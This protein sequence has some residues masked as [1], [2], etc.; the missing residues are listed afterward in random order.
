M[1]P[2]VDAA[3]SH[4]DLGFII[5]RAVPDRIA[6]MIRSYQA[7]FA[8]LPG[9]KS[10]WAQALR[11]A[12]QYLPFVE[13]ALPQYLDELRGLA[14]GSGAT[15]DELLLCNCFE[16]LT[17][18]MLF[19]KCTT[20]AFAPEHTVDGH[21]LLGHTEDW[22][23]I[24]RDWQYVVRARPDDEPAFISPV[25]GGLLPNVGF[26]AGGLAQCINTVYPD[27][28]RVGI[29][30][31]F[32]GRHVLAAPRLG[33]AVERA[34]HPHR[35]A[36]YN[37]VLADANGELY[38]V[39]TTATR[40]DL[41]YAAD[42]HLTHTN[43]YLSPRLRDHEADVIIGANLRVNRAARLAKQ[44]LAR[45]PIDFSAIKAILADHNN[46][47]YSICAH[48]EDVPPRDQTVTISAY[49]IDLTAR[50]L[51]YCYGQPCTGEFVPIGLED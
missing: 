50:T 9:F 40:A 20:V 16:E 47:P 26:N 22:L 32:I 13:E 10:T 44:A 30:R 36:G 5:G 21:V 15:F 1:V 3:G 41:L 48:A 38:N 12:R 29:P 11:H 39:E 42:G 19:E 14:D 25:Y 4:Y 8:N 51:W 43:N 24:D 28:A 34:L 23:P 2:I 46:Y 37:H 31:L 6:G 33:L 45:G 27:D 49:V 7:L 35:A 18:D 17:D